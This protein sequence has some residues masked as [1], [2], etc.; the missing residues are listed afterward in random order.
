MPFPFVSRHSEPIS[1]PLS[2]LESI[3]EVL[4]IQPP[5]EKTHPFTIAVYRPVAKQ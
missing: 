3:L 2:K 4:E 5:E 1:F